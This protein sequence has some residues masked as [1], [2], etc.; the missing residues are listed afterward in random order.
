MSQ[1]R[2]L[3]YDLMTNV[4]VAEL[5]LTNVNFSQQLN[6]AGTF[7]GE[8]LISDQSEAV[9][10]IVYNTRPGKTA[11]YVERSDADNGIGP[12]LLWGGI[13]WSRSYDSVTQKITLSAR[14]FESYFER[15]L[16]HAVDFTG[17]AND[18]AVTFSNV[19]QLLVAASLF[20][21]AQQPLVSSSTSNI[22]VQVTGVASNPVQ[23]IT[24]TYYDYEHKSYFQAVQ[25]LSQSD[26]GFDFNISVYY[27]ANG[28]PRKL[29]NVAYPQLGVR[30]KASETDAT[31]F[32][33]PGNIVS[34]TYAEDSAT[35]TNRAITL[36]SGS[37][38]AQLTGI[39]FGSSMSDNYPASWPLLDDAYSFTDY[40]DIGLLNQL[41]NG[42]IAAFNY[43]VA[44]LNVVATASQA[45]W[46]GSF[47]V[48]DDVRVIINDDR[49]LTA[50][51]FV[52]R[53]TAITIAPGEN[54]GGELVTLSLTLPT[55]VY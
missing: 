21:A 44:T 31:V 27:D 29:L 15:V 24:R 9:E 10:N 40:N 43:P 23:P 11:L 51:D 8:I 34:Y 36:G 16:I 37:N 39:S 30:Y 54:S 1:Y 35:Q 20:T 53:L 48:A 19:D 17:N 42:R 32:Q 33:M 4:A 18:Q 52:Y 26:N 38:E 55:N 14:E 13:I 7:Q 28:V 3:F 47:N 45:P 50:L 22:G 12:S 41:A 6:S 49:F 46:I 5:S 2:Y 25:D